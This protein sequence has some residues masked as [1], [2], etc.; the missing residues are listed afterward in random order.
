VR[1]ARQKEV[2]LRLV[3]RQQPPASLDAVYRRY[4]RYV[5]AVVL[6]LAGR[7]AEVDDLI[8][9]VFVEAAN[10]IGALRDPE[11]V[12]GWLATIAVRVVRHRLRIRRLRRLVGL[13]TGADY[14]TIADHAASPIDKMLIRVVYRVLD[15]LA[16]EDRLAFSLHAIEGEKLETVAK[17]CGCSCAT[18]KRRI[19]RAQAAIQERLADE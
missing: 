2:V 17:L 1:P 15:D 3:G 12:R 8:Q 5:A 16:V 11:A 6:K 18:A 13:D 7:D 10:G 19:A 4:C 14:T 9:D